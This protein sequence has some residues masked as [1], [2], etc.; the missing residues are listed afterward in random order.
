MKTRL[1]TKASLLASTLLPAMLVTVPAQAQDEPSVIGD[2]ITVTARRREESLQDVPLSVSAFTGDQL[3][4]LGAPDITGLAEVLPNVTLEVSRGTNSTLSAFIRGVGQQDPVAGFEAGV[5]IYIDDVYL[6]RPQGAVLDIFDVERIEVLRGPQGTL[7]GRNTIGGAVKFVTRRLDAENPTFNAR[8]NYGEYGQFDQIV[9]GSVPLGD[10]F[11]VGGAVANL[12]R[13]GFGEN[14]LTGE[15]NYNKDVLGL[16]VSAEFEPTDNLFFRVSYDRTEDDSNPRHGHR[17]IPG[18]LSGAPVLD[19][20]FDSRAGLSVP[21]QSVEAE[22]YSVLAEWTINEN[23]TVKNIFAEREDD[24]SSPIDFDSLPSGDLDVP[25]I[26]T[27]EQLTEE[28]QVLYTG[29][30]LAGV[31]GFFY[32]DA[33][34]FNVF[35]VLLDNVLPGLNAQTFGDVDTETWSLF[36]NFTYDMTDE[37]SLTLGGRYTEDERTS[38]VLRRTYLGGF[39]EFFGGTGAVIATTSDFNDSNSWDDFSPTVSLAWQPDAANNYYVTFSQGFK[40]GGF[41]PRAQS[42]AAPDLDGDGVGL[43]TNGT[44]DPDDVFEFMSF[45]PEQ[46][47]SYEI[48][49]KYASSN[50]QHSLAL[51]HMDYQDVQVPGSVGIDTDGDGVSDSFTGVTT[52]A[53]AATIRGIEYEGLAQLGDDLF[54]DGDSLSMNWAIGIL[55]GEYDEFINAFGVDVSEDVVIQNTPDYTASVQLSYVTPAFGGDIAFNNTLSLRG[56]SSQFE[57]PFPELDQ[58]S[59]ALWNASLLWESTDGHWE[60]GLHGRNLTDQEY[61]VSGYDFVNNDTLAPELGLEGTLTAFYGAPRTVTATVAWR[62]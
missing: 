24:T 14:L 13:D 22:G 7:Y 2:T 6:N 58:S 40:G 61:R 48:G 49:W 43:T 3:E 26:Y 23:W 4:D 21:E 5:G 17:L 20:V 45:D 51:F 62:Y 30:K 32:M 33:N 41:D 1:V 18:V 55:D 47:D 54:N 15:D 28:F 60:L 34:A 52:N 19:N 12:T 8:I 9:S 35:D 53:G 57:F 10:Y 37:L 11:R 31:M 39:S 59:Y 16:R 50:Y 25:V 29:E 27:N 38:R 42:T 56:D 46:V 36:A 44:T